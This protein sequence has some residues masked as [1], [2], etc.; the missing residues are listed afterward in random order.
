MGINPWRR[1]WKYNTKCVTKVWNACSY[2]EFGYCRKTKA[3]LKKINAK[4]MQC[5]HSTCSTKSIKWDTVNNISLFDC[6]KFVQIQK[7]TMTKHF[8]SLYALNI[9]II[10]CYEL[11][12]LTAIIY[13]QS[14]SRLC[15]YTVYKNSYIFASVDLLWVFIYSVS[16]YGYLILHIMMSFA[17]QSVYLQVLSNAA[18]VCQ[19]ITASS[20]VKKIFHG[21]INLYFLSQIPYI[22]VIENLFVSG[23][24]WIEF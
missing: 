4:N 10:D 17:T 23:L 14:P 15:L 7:Q 9:W 12:L 20:S 6:S 11:I 3:I 1:I 8:Y 13:W 21:F 2:D 16:F 22:F 19:T 24:F 18:I 5:K